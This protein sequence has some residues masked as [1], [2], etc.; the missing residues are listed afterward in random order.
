MGRS[1]PHTAASS[2]ASARAGAAGGGGSVE[3]QQ[4][5]RHPAAP[6]LPPTRIQQAGRLHWHRP[7]AAP[8]SSIQPAAG[9]GAGPTPESSPL[10]RLGAPRR[11]NC[12][13]LHFL[14]YCANGGKAEM[15][16]MSSRAM[17]TG[18]RAPDGG[19]ERG[20][21][22]GGAQPCRRTLVASDSTSRQSLLMQRLWA[23]GSLSPS[24]LS[25]AAS[26]IGATAAVA[27]GPKRPRSRPRCRCRARRLLPCTRKPVSKLER[28]EGV[29]PASLR[30][31]QARRRGEIRC[32]PQAG[33]E[34]NQGRLTDCR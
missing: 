26:L 32:R 24:G 3:A 23:R 16:R 20:G 11:S 10:L 30:R 33:S 7:V 17:A 22:G 13:V 6:V 8:I 34:L 2:R 21:G 4:H 1:A 28:A 31:L 19:G 14:Q 27:A 12:C 15:Q 25:F 5:S 18:R 9:A 29:R